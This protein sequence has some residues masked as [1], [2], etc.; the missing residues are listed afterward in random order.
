MPWCMYAHLRR[1]DM[2]GSRTAPTETLAGQALCDAVVRERPPQRP[3]AVRVCAIPVGAFR[4]TP[5]LLQH[6]NPP[7]VVGVLSRTL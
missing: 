2:G 7:T 6:I 5:A 1:A 3:I 4:E